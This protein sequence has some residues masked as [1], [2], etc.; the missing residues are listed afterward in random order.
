MYNKK[1]Y[2]TIFDVQTLCTVTK[3]TDVTENFCNITLSNGKV[4]G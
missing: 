1:F 4:S 2:G 3:K